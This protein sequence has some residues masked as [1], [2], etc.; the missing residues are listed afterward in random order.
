MFFI[1]VQTGITTTCKLGNEVLVS[2]CGFFAGAC[3]LFNSG[4]A[5]HGGGANRGMSKALAMVAVLLMCPGDV[6]QDINWSLAWTPVNVRNF[7]PH[8]Q[9]IL[10]A[11]AQACD[12]HYWV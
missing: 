9:P 8:F 4:L 2:H 3:I 6:T 7:K 12:H 5:S 10:A 1:T 11:I